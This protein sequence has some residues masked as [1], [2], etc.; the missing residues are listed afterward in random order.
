MMNSDYDN[1]KT[2]IE[3]LA[4]RYLR[5]LAGEELAAYFK[6]LARYPIELVEKATAAA[7]ERYPTFFPNV[8][9]L[10]EICDSLAAQEL[11]A[12]DAVTLL[13]S[14]AECEHED[15]F[16]PEPEGSL[17]AGFDVCVRCGRAKPRLSRAAPPVQLRYFG[18]AVNP[19][20]GER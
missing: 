20:G 14:T 8:G 10:I 7:P 18:M 13:R 15:R 16:E 2:A 12:V 11:Y 6:Q 5:G 9:Q 3:D 19:R 4:S 17:Y 1:F